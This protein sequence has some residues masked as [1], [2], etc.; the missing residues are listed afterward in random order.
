[1]PNLKLPKNNKNQKE[2]TS[3]FKNNKINGD[4]LLTEA[5]KKVP[6]PIKQFVPDL[7]IDSSKDIDVSKIMEKSSLDVEGLLSKSMN[8]NAIMEKVQFGINI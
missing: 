4:G 7:K 2:L 3:L 6:E 8:M 1:M 5:K